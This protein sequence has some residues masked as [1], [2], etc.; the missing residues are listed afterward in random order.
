MELLT[1]G[2]FGPPSTGISFRSLIRAGSRR[3]TYLRTVLRERTAADLD[4]CVL[5]L[6]AVHEADGYPV[7]W[8][9]EPGRWLDPPGVLAAWVFADPEIAGHVLVTSPGEVGRLFVTP[10]HRGRGIGVRLLTQVR[11]WASGR[12]LGLVLEVVDDGRSAAVA[13]YEG[14]GWTHQGTFRADW[15]GPGGEPVHVRRYSLPCPA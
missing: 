8:P 7:N 11:A 10:S 5:A 13:L 15:T 1:I 6:R 14:T 3:L 12:G 2:A 4:A 9:R